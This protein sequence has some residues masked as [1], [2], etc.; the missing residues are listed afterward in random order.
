MSNLFESISPCILQAARIHKFVEKK[1]GHLTKLEVFVMV[2]RSEAVCEI[3]RK[4]C[5][6]LPAPL[7]RDAWQRRTLDFFAAEAAKKRIDDCHIVAHKLY[8]NRNI[9]L[10]FSAYCFERRAHLR[11]EV[12][13]RSL[14][15]RAFDEVT[16]VRRLLRELER[17]TTF[18]TIIQCPEAC[19]GI[20]PDF[21]TIYEFI[22]R[23]GAEGREEESNMHE[24]RKLKNQLTN[25]TA[26]VGYFMGAVFA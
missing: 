3:L 1:P 17:W 18:L 19:E 16:A 22:T 24:I 2:E 12:S 9:N 15:G 13:Q 10:G 4:Q 20:K 6:M 5:A 7:I 25:E 14:S 8:A 21:L 23:V 26:N 11:V